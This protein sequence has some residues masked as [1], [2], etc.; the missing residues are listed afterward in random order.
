VPEP[1]NQSTNLPPPKPQQRN[2]KGWLALSLLVAGGAGFSLGYGWHE[3]GHSWRTPL[4]FLIPLVYVG[5]GVVNIHRLPAA[6]L[7]FRFGF[8]VA[9][10]A[11]AA[12]SFW[13]GME[14]SPYKVQDF[15][16]RD[17]IFNIA[18]GFCCWLASAS[19][20]G[21]GV[22]RANLAERAMQ[23]RKKQSPHRL[24]NPPKAESELDVPPSCDEGVKPKKK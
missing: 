13:L 19:I 8:L 18:K 16:F 2:Q 9:Y 6:R 11:V 3:E 15:M 21:L 22:I 20:F 23:R 5:I 14:V 4:M 1:A 12:L 17:P 10:S 7:D 24:T